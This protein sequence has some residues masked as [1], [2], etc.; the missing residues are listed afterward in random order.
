MVCHASGPLQL[1]AGTY[2]CSL[3]RCHEQLFYTLEE[4]GGKL[5]FI[6]ENDSTPT[7]FKKSDLLLEVWCFL[8]IDKGSLVQILLKKKCCIL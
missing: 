8:P 6:C 7:I 4:D 1:Q 2:H 3:V 5:L